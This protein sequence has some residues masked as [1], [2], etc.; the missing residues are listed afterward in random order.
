M[1]LKKSK[2]VKEKKL[3]EAKRIKD[4]ERKKVS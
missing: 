4:K 2:V 3:R 1:D